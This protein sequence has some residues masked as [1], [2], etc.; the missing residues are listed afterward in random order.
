MKSNA[1]LTEEYFDTSLAL[2][3][4]IEGRRAAYA[5][6]QGSTAIVHHKV[7]ACS[8][9]PRLFNDESWSTLKT[10]AETTHRILCKVIDHYLKDPT[11]R[12]IF[13]YDKRLEELIL[14]PRGYNDLLP[15]AR[16][17]VFL[18]EDDMSC[19]FCEFN[20]DGSAGMNENREI[21]NSISTTQTFKQFAQTHSIETCEL[22]ESWVEKFIDIFQRSKHATPD[23]RFAICDYLECGVVDEFKV[24]AEYFKQHGY[25]CVVCDVRDLHFDGTVLRDKEGLPINAIW[26]RCVTNDVM[27]YWDESQ[28]LIEA[29]RHEAVA[30]IGSFA[31]HIVHDKQIFEALYHPKTQAILTEE[32]NAFIKR[33]VPRTVFLNDNDVDISE[34]RAHKNEWII[35]PTDSYGARDVYAGLA[36]DEQ[37]WNKLI[38]T[39][40]NEASGAPFIA[41]TYITPFKTHTL[42]PDSTI[43]N[44]ADNEIDTQGTWYNNLSG[45]YLYNGEFQGIFSRLGPH[46]TISK[47]NEGMTAATLHVRGC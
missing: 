10:I 26:R 17:D 16:I 18:N 30:L 33:H 14:L 15:F 2:N 29:L 25:D 20:G 31:G 40:A 24:F 45:L 23:A 3:G 7:V 37:E 9:I 38:D 1:E 34:V 36:L 21:T 32:E 8:F 6:M 28:D 35:K 27:D 12:D 41:Q 22:F 44:L 42:A 47:E 39:Y 46:P 19:G 11:Y 4:D 5:Y 13:S 43:E